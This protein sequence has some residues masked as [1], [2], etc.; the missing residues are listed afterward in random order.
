MEMI[1][2]F[3]ALKN[4]ISSGYPFIEAI[5][6]ALPLC[7]EFVISE[8]YSS[9][10]TYDVLLDF[11][12]DDERVKIF[13][14][15]WDTKSLKGSALRN[16]LNKAR[17]RCSEKYVMEIDANEIITQDNIE[18]IKSL[19]E[20]YPKKELFAFPYYQ[21]LGSKIMFAEEFRFRLA[22]NKKSIRVLWDGYNMGYKLTLETLFDRGTMKRVIN[23]ALTVILEDRIA[24]GYVPEQFIYLPK[25]IF[26]YYAIFPEN[27]FNKMKM[28]EYLQ[29][30]R[31]YRIFRMDDLNSPFKKIMEKF[32]STGDY[33]A[34]WEEIYSLHLDL[35]KEGIN[36]NKDFTEKK[37]I[38]CKAQPEIIKP[39]LGKAR[40]IPT[41]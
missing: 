27:F 32:D 24:G 21:I 18:L 20:K 40:Y 16:V 23:R 30:S 29:P 14:D 9:D 11:F 31:D 22:Q 19:P 1:S 2:C 25:P 4:G 35:I 7:E 17:F 15:R 39:Q 10:N 34:F 26:K 28:K 33:D 37:I 5:K 13:R 6:A 38:D 41:K 3:M 12:S 8:G 36:I